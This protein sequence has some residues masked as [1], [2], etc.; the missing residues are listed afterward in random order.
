M[1]TP[2]IRSQPPP[3]RSVSALVLV[4]LSFVSAACATVR[5]EQRQ[6]LADPTMQYEGSRRDER[7]REHVLEYREGAVGGGSVKGGGCGCN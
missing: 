7:A 5:P 1:K 4:A 2:R 3:A 6:L